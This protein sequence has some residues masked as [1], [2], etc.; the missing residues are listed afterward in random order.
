MLVCCFLVLEGS[1]L[2]PWSS[3]LQDK[4]AVIEKQYSG[5]R[6]PACAPLPTLPLSL[7]LTPLFR[8]I[9][10]LALG[11]ASIQRLN[12]A[13]EGRLLLP[14]DSSPTTPATI[15]ELDCGRLPPPSPHRSHEGIAVVTF[16][17]SSRQAEQLPNIR[18]GNQMRKVTK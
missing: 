5:R 8:V 4:G 3:K 6:D 11:L 15:V 9:T 1:F 16:I 18:A 14:P 2:H 12:A 7:H 17:R 10:Y 13:E